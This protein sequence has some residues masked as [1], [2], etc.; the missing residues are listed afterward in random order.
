ML[1]VV[2]WGLQP[3]SDEICVD[4]DTLR[5]SLFSTAPEQSRLCLPWQLDHLMS[6]RHWASEW[7]QFKS[8]DLIRHQPRRELLIRLLRKYEFMLQATPLNQAVLTVLHFLE[9]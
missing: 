5:Q 4:L 7:L 9:T 1:H 3:N 2:A 6:F 8:V